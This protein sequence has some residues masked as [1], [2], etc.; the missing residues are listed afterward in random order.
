MNCN[1]IRDLLPLYRDGVCSDETIQAVEKHLETCTDC[2]TVY[3][4]M[5]KEPVVP[6]P[7]RV[8]AGQEA[9]VLRGVK[10]K[11]SMRRWFSVLAVALVS[12]A[13]LLM[14]TA[15][16]DIEKAIP[17][18]NGLID[19]RLAVDEA[20]D[21]HFFGDHYATF[22]AFY[23][24][25]ENGY[26]V[27]FCYTQTLKSSLA[28]IPEDH[29]HIC[30]GNALMTDFNTASYQVPYTQEI[31]AVYYLE[32]GLRDYLFMSEM[33]DAEFAGAAQDAVLLWER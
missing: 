9:R 7:I 15:A 11:F 26:A 3:E 20:I 5:L 30:I 18:Q 17:Y 14:F 24:E 12:L 32:A 10:R 33:S 21:I 27:Y 6:E 31:Q 1:I 4:E 28:P 29:G 16:S 13:T 2:R 25:T 22:R 8:Q 23:R 19:A